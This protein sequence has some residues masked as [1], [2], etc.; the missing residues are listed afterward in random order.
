LRVLPTRD[1]LRKLL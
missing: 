1:I